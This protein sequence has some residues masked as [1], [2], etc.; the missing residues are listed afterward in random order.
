MILEGEWNTNPS[1]IVRLRGRDKTPE[2]VCETQ[3]TVIRKAYA[4]EGE[5]LRHHC[6]WLLYLELFLA[7]DR[8][9]K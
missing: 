6:I 7:F 9:G 5:L 2:Y 3:Q 4:T 1:P 8:S